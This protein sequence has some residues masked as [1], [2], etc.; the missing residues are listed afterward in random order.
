MKKQDEGF[1]LIELLIVIVI[2][3]ILAAVVVF[4][5]GGITDQGQ[6]S[7]CDAEKKTVEVALEAY[8]AQTG[9]YPATMADLTAED[10]E[11]LRD[12]PSW[13]D[14]NGDGELLAPSPAPNGD[15]T[16]PCTV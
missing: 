16:N 15:T 5:V 14:I 2:L 8:R 3:G 13:Y 10:A 6:E 11:F 1:T 4:A 12:D 7:S 9:D